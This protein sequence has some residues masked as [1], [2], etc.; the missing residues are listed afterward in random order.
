MG[1]LCSNI[2]N[3]KNVNQD[4][5]KE[6][7]FLRDIGLSNIYNVETNVN[8]CS[9][10]F[11]GPQYYV[12]GATD[13]FVL[14]TA[15]S[16]CTT[17]FTTTTSSYKKCP[18]GYVFSAGTSGNTCY[19]ISGTTTATTSATTF[20]VTQTLAT[21]NLSETPNFDI[22]FLI[23]GDTNYTAYTGNF[24]YKI[25]SKEN[26]N[27]NGDI[28]VLRSGS[29]V[30]NNCVLFTDIT[31]GSVT[32]QFFSGNTPNTWNEYLIR[33]FYTFKT[34]SCSQGQNFNQ[35]VSTTQLNQFNSETDFYFMT[36]IN[37]PKP[38]LAGPSLEP[39]PNYNFIQD[40]LLTNG[41]PGPRGPQAIN[42][43]L[44][45][46]TLKTTPVSQ[47]IML[48]LNGVKLTEGSDYNLI[49]Y[50][51]LLAPPVVKI[52]LA[53]IKN[54]DWLVAN[55]LVG[56]PNPLSGPLNQW[57]V[58]TIYVTGITVDINPGYATS[59]NYNTTTGNQE[60]YLTQPIEPSNAIFLTINGVQMVENQQFF[61]STSVDNKIIFD[62][63][64]TNLIVTGDVV[65]VFT[66]SKDFIYGGYDYG[67]L[68]TNE[69]KPNWVVST[70]LPE[71]VTSNFKVQVALKSDTGYTS[72]YYEK[73][74]PFINGVGNYTSTISSIALNNDYRFRIVNEAV[75][76]GY[77]NNKIKTCSSSEG[78]FST[79]SR[80]I[81]NTY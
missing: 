69:F 28:K 44:N 48:F 78:F 42:N 35:W 61:K 19:F 36:V 22:K 12:T 60:M 7:I 15:N 50:N 3:K 6:E 53:P 47:N 57:F 43:E 27:V 55:Y 29:E 67:Q 45:Y 41:L 74:I 49:Y 62:K 30:I 32:Q 54:S 20:I 1:F 81:N 33:P 76:T 5:L 58:N 10:I 80:Y 73:V 77:L 39:L 34:T 2:N 66:V 52:N 46:F 13:L 70:T 4:S 9:E 24:C 51:G 56:Q 11:N 59:I 8:V 64:Y 16:G 79:T 38:E 63:T 18:T 17:G 37:P 25:F 26:F 14:N 75:Y 23:T 71:N 72:V 40:T 68:S 21:Y 65:S 31:G